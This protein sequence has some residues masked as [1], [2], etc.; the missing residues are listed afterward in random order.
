[1]KH[2]NIGSINGHEPSFCLSFAFSL[3][4]P[5][6]PHFQISFASC[7]LAEQHHKLKAHYCQLVIV[8]KY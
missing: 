1:M 6:S 7:I 2:E 8:L 4:L 5:P 3:K